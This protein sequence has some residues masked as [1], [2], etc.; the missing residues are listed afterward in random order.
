M[1][2]TTVVDRAV[3]YDLR[4]RSQRHRHHIVRPAFATIHRLSGA[5]VAEKLKVLDAVVVAD[6]VDVVD[7]LSSSERPSKVSGHDEAVFKDHH[8]ATVRMGH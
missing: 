1:A 5:V 6:A 8:S 7:V 4:S 2:F 3:G